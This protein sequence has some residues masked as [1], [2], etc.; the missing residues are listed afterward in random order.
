MAVLAERRITPSVEVTQAPSASMT[1][2]PVRSGGPRS[3][4]SLEALLFS[5]S[6]P[7]DEAILAK[8]LPSDADV[9]AALQQLQQEYAPRGVNLVRVAGNGRSARPRI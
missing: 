3:C 6:E 9:H 1:Q 2:A 7:L 4:V 8:R 5:A